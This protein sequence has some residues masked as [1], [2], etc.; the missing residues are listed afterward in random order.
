L[1]SPLD[2]LR[3]IASRGLLK[4]LCSSLPLVSFAVVGPLLLAPQLAGTT[5]IVVVV[6]RLEIMEYKEAIDGF[7]EILTQKNLPSQLKIVELES[8]T[9]NINAGI[10]EKIQAEQPALI[11]TVGTVSSKYVAQHIK[12]LPIVF[13]MVLAPGEAGLTTENIVGAS[14]DLPAKIQLENLEAVIPHLK[15]V[16][17]IYHP[18]ENQELM[19]QAETAAGELGLLLKTY[20]VKAVKEIPEL[21]DLNIDVLWIIPDSIVCQ[22]VILKRILLSSLRERIPV[23]GFSR[24]FANSG[25][26]LAVSCD[27]KDIGRQA[28]ELAARILQG[29]NYSRLKTSV[30][31]TTK[32]YLNQLVANRM[33]INIPKKILENAAEVLGK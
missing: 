6:E 3:L 29:E 30:P 8:K 14:L 24:S 23:M 19:R 16:G 5:T 9:E 28:G 10:I 20:P 27:Y 25:A 1:K 11:L 13:S 12:D 2:L 21:V 22:P 15:R 18:P 17:V 4:I 32:L 7:N 33:G 31:R 26:L